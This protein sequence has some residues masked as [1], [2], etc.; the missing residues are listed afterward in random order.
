MLRQLHLVTHTH[1]YI[2][3]ST[4]THISAFNDK[5]TVTSSKIPK[6]FKNSS[7]KTGPAPSDQS[8]KTGA[9]QTEAKFHTDKRKLL[10]HSK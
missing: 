10:S 8:T 9:L 4:H 1:T 7:S 3:T 2:Q 5:R 6:Q